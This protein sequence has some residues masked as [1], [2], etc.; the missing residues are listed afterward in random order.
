VLA[1]LGVMVYILLRH[2][3]SDMTDLRQ[4]THQELIE[5]RNELERSGLDQD[6]AEYIA[7]IHRRAIARQQERAFSPM[8][9]PS[10]RVIW[11]RN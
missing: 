5:G 2:M 9:M 3:E 11:V 6:A 4:M 8:T 10:G 7:E 1:S